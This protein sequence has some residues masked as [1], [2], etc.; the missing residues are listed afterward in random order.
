MKSN[1]IQK[2]FLNFIAYVVGLIFI[3]TATSYLTATF[4][5]DEYGELN[6]MTT[7]IGAGAIYNLIIIY[8]YLGKKN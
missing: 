4:L 8:Y 5:W 2:E 3:V 6:G 7:G 1:L